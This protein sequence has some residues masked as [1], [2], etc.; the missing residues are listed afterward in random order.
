MRI[1]QL[2]SDAVVFVGDSYE[3]VATA[4]F[5][6]DDAVL[7]DA[8]A[9]DTDALR[10]KQ[11]LEGE[12]GKRVRMVIATHYMT[13]HIAGLKLF[14][15][16]IIVAHRYFMHTFATQRKR[17]PRDADA[18]VRPNIV[19]DEGMSLHWGRYTLDVFHNPGKTMCKLNIDVPQADVVIAGDN[20]VGNTVYLSRAAPE[21][22]DAALA[23]LQRRGRRRVIGGHM[24]VMPARVLENARLYLA[25]IRDS[26]QSIRQR[27]PENEWEQQIR[28]IGIASC[29][30]PGVDP[31]PFEIEWHGRNLD[32]IVE[33][34][35]FS[36]TTFPNEEGAMSEMRAA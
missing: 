23:R 27:F 4:F 20:V 22:I 16:A 36:V 10:M 19:I 13:D 26:V 18:F 32:V 35:T 24:G 5:D 12:L 28:Q 7:V 9:S 31:A 8:L 14:P 2:D 25:R 3:S 29:L 33:Q 6:G 17:T 30:A 21:L 15:D 11:H 34:G 1:E